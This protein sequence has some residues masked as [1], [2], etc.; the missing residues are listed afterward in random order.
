MHKICAPVAKP[1]RHLPNAKKLLILF[2]KTNVGEID[3]GCSQDC[4]V[5]NK[6]NIQL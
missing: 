5:K 3:P 2:S 4:D 6:G 1:V